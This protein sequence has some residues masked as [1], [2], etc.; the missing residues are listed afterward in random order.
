M[1]K[2][3]NQKVNIGWY[4]TSTHLDIT[5]LKDGILTNYGYFFFYINL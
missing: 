5:I 4:L 1:D 3:V 2:K